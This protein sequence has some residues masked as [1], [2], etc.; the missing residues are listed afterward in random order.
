MSTS[1]PDY[2]FEDQKARDETDK[3]ARE[4][5]GSH[6]LEI[7]APKGSDAA[8]KTDWVTMGGSDKTVDELDNVSMGSVMIGR[9]Y[10]FKIDI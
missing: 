9:L 3:K 10:A 5:L 8:K 7:K 1:G 4:L 2:N 6:Y